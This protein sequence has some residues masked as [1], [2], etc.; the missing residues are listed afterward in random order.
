M[1]EQ[2]ALEGENSVFDFLYQ[3]ARRVGS[4][5][6]Q[7]NPAG[8]VQGVKQTVATE[9]TGDGGAK[10]SAGASA[11]VAR[12]GGDLS[13]QIS[14]T[15]R[16]SLGRTFDP[17]WC[18]AIEL[19]DFLETKSLIGRDISETKIGEFVLVS[20]SLGILDAALLKLIWTVPEVR[21]MLEQGVANVALQPGESRKE[22]IAFSKTLVKVL[23]SLP[24]SI[25]IR[26]RDVPG[27]LVY[28]SIHEAGLISTTAE[29]FFKHGI[30]VPGQ[31]SV[32]GILDA[33]PGEWLSDNPKIDKDLGLSDTGILPVLLN[34]MQG[35]MREAGRLAIAYGLTPLLILRKAGWVQGEPDRGHTNEA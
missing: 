4:F 21:A 35:L 7:L 15:N 28:C 32:L 26:L 30:A 9:E 20:G 10:I 29:L 23:M 5:L 31:W 6:A 24:E 11:L 17:L 12:A 22:K 19:L 14:F 8:H 1:Q 3:D 27:H 13:G 18:N 33:H 2:D 16:D 25:Q 34:G